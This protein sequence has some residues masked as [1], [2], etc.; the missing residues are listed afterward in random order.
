MH[1]STLGRVWRSKQARPWPRSEICEQAR[2]RR[3]WPGRSIAWWSICYAIIMGRGGEH[4]MRMGSGGK[5]IP[6]SDRDRE[7]HASQKGVR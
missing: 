2:D 7:R 6:S 1:R 3:T 4:S 5:R